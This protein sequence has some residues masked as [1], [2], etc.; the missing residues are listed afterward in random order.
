MLNRKSYSSCIVSGI[1]INKNID[2]DYT[3][4]NSYMYSQ[5]CTV[6]SAKKINS[7]RYLYQKS[8]SR[9]RGCNKHVPYQ[10]VFFG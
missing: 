3:I 9:D 5:S 8:Y 7:V 1:F 6:N 10:L 2:M 4:K